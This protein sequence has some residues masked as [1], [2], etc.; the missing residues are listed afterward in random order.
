[1]DEQLV[2]Q[3]VDKWMA[4]TLEKGAT[5]LSAAGWR[6]EARRRVLENE[7]AWPGYIE[8]TIRGITMS[9]ESYDPHR[10]RDPAEILR[11]LADAKIDELTRYGVR[12][13]ERTRM[14]V[15]YA[16]STIY[17]F[18][19]APFPPGG[20]G[21]LENELYRQLGFDRASGLR[22]NP[23]SGEVGPPPRPPTEIG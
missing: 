22:F 21:Q 8:T 14:A 11:R 7:R 19:C 23:R 2:E 17:T 16:C 3:V 4:E 1:M 10:P 18:R 12:E 15:D 9:S 5:I 6:K 13:P 20:I